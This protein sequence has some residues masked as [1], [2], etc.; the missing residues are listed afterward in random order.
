MAPL[1]KALQRRR[2]QVFFV[3]SPSFVPIIQKAGFDAFP[4][5]ID[6]DESR[7]CETVP[8][9]IEIPLTERML[10]LSKV[11]FLERSPKSMVPD[12][13]EI[14]DDRSPDV[15][16]YNSFE[17][18]APIAAELKGIPMAG[19]H[20]SF[21]CSKAIDSEFY[22]DELES[23][24]SYFGLQPDPKMS[25][26]GRWLELSLLP[27]TWV[28]PGFLQE[29]TEFFI[30][31]EVFDTTGEE[32][33]PTWINDLPKQPTIHASLGTVFNDQP[34]VFDCIFD[35]LKDARV[36]L[37]MTVGRS[38]DPNR[39]GK[40]PAHI[41]VERYIPTSLLLPHMDI[42]INHGG[43]GSVMAVLTKGIPMIILPLSA[44]QPFIASIA[45]N[46]GVAIPLPQEVFHLS[47]GDMPP[48]VDPRRISPE[49]IRMA[50][51][52]A[53]ENNTY[54][55][56]ALKLAGRLKSMPGADFAA[57]LLERLGW[58]RKP[59]INSQPGINTWINH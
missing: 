5:G 8:E 35:A 53:F 33:I 38:S 58:D 36:N 22:G 3:C 43:N 12:M 29:P 32:R 15:I 21:R 18:A 48:V 11:I 54:R 41:K 17:I 45:L 14:I 52:R 50:V 20:I 42:S 26:I 49:V 51:N 23:L 27:P 31:P 55:Q 10:W 24:R 19:V 16:I 13:L 47:Q 28:L 40:L 56:S 37:I 6:W 34:A 1:A 25:W 46:H 9:I 2:H 7:L 39:Y 30:R 4:A 57:E 44:D 59:I